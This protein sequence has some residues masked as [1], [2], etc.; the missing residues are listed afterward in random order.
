M[1]RRAQDIDIKLAACWLAAAMGVLG[2][3]LARGDILGIQSNASVYSINETTGASTLRSNNPTFA[4]NAMAKNSVGTYYTAGGLGNSLLNTINPT[5]GVITAGL[6]ISGNDDVRGLAFSPGDVLYA[7]IAG[8][9]PSSSLY[10]I[11][12]S[13][14]ATTLIAAV[15]PMQALTFS[16]SGTLYGWSSLLG[17]VTI[18][19]ATGGVTDVDPSVGSA[20]GIQTLAFSPGGVLYAGSPDLYIVDVTTG[21]LTLVAPITPVNNLRGMEFMSARN[22]GRVRE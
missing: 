17:L 20:E 18:D 22:A 13:T 4:A 12:V 5:T 15:G 14:G 11:N 8:G 21:E 6:F 3:P 1:Q 7:T 19:P 2:A 10:T 9:S 16:A